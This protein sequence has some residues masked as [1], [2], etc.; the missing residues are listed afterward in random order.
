MLFVDSKID[1]GEFVLHLFFQ[2]PLSGS[3]ERI[4]TA[5][6]EFASASEFN[7]VVA[8]KTFGHKSD[9]CFMLISKDYEK[10]LG[11]QRL[12]KR[13]LTLIWSYVSLTE[14]SEYAANLPD[15]I[16]SQRL[17]PK[18]PPEGLSSWCFYPMSKRR[19]PNYNWYE[20]SYDIR[21]KLMKEHGETGRLFRGNV[22]QLVTGSIGLDDWE[23]GVT[24]FAKNPQVIKECVYKMRFDEVSSKY[25]DFGP[26]ITGLVVDDLN[27]AIDD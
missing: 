6:L 19:N 18:L 1:V 15:E 23:W 27:Q 10:L 16:K 5:L 20:L 12:L 25:A 8:V 22:I 3:M 2:I 24:L 14:V 21:L 17:Y 11:I 4:K 7:Q 26:F 13:E 9:L